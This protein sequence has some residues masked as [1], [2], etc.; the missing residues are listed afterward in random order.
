MT[1]ASTRAAILPI[2]LSMAASR[3]SSAPRR[4]GRRLLLRFGVI[5]ALPILGVGWLLDRQITAA[6]DVLGD[7]TSLRV[8]VVVGLA[9]LW[10]V[11]ILL[12]ASMSQ[13]LA[14]QTEEN[15][16]L[17][18]VDPVT[19]LASR[20][21]LRE[22]LE[23]ALTA[24]GTAP[25]GLL[26]VD[27]D[28]FKEVNDTLG[29]SNGDALLSHVA[30]TLRG[31]TRS[32]DTVARLGGD[33][34][35]VVAR[36]IGTPEL[37]TLAE[38][39]LA[40]LRMPIVVDGVDVAVEA[41]VGMAVAPV[42]GD[43]AEMLLQRADIAMYAA[44]TAKTGACRYDSDLDPH[45]PTRLALAAEL[46]RAID[47]HQLVVHYQPIGDARS[48]AVTQVEA[49]VRWQHPKRGL[50]RPSEFLPLAERSGLIHRVTLRVFDLSLAQVRAWRDQGLEL[51]VSMNLAAA[52]LRNTALADRLRELLQKHRVDPS[53]V[54]VELSEHG[55][56][57]DP[58]AALLLVT[59][60]RALG[61]RIALDAFGVGSSSLAYLRS[62]RADVLKIDQSFVTNLE[63]SETDTNIVRALV[64]LAHI[65]GMEVTAEG[66]E[67]AA[68]WGRLAQLDCDT[69]QG[70]RLAKAMSAD[71][72]G[73]YLAFGIVEAPD[74][75]APTV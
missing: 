22:Q 16:R 65:L 56:L 43:T 62:I 1:V 46:A 66:V 15:R 36:R 29:H 75:A 53:W 64:E 12:V 41:S 19:G 60:L 74:E 47:R 3:V 17:V 42:D 10:L 54:Q 18:A 51:T 21:E 26:L 6:T 69:I 59:R 44:K 40:A 33:E 38:R 31:T 24:P 25:V 27:L 67:T 58:D 2:T 5:T 73:A 8:T 23:R 55:L 39:I 61:V 63:Q 68:Q 28:D 30:S 45:S 71:E 70:Y 52:D 35:A 72:L 57:N 9:A 7:V 14:R 48:G 32:T 13:R 20:A 4:G 11:T 50:L 37:E 34:F 49:L